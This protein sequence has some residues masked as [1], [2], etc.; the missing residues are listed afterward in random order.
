M[1]ST[2][3]Q[4]GFTL[5]ELLVVIGILAILGVIALVSLDPKARL[6]DA[7]DAMR[8]NDASELSSS[9]EIYSVNYSNDSSDI[10]LIDKLT[11]GEVYMIGAAAIGCDDKNLFCGIK[12]TS[13]HHC[14]DLSALV[15]D[16]YL[17]QIPVSP[18][19]KTSWSNDL[20]GYTLQKDDS[21]IIHV[22]SC[23]AENR[24]AIDITF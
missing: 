22:R 21:G 20:T 9:L 11:Q 19:E 4:R 12:V 6:K 23:E 13:E 7:R 18:S 10:F 14:I 8:F 5:I 15:S 16:G 2:S 17:A 24:E 3:H 1:S